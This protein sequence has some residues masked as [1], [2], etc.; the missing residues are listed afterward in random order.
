MPE[1]LF[2][3]LLLLSLI[4]VAALLFGRQYRALAKPVKI[5]S[6]THYVRTRRVLIIYIILFAIETVIAFQRHD[7]TWL[8]KLLVP[9]CFALGCGSF[10]FVFLQAR[11]KMRG[12]PGFAEK[13]PKRPAPVFLWQAIL[14]LLPVAVLALFGLFSLRQ[15]KLLAGQE[16]K[17]FGTVIAER[18]A[19]AIGTNVEQQLRDYREANFD[20]N[21][22]RTTDLGLSS[23]K[24]GVQSESN[25]W[26]RIKEWQQANP[27]INLPAMPVSDC[28]LDL[29]SESSSPQIY[30][31]APQP[32][33]WLQQLTPEQNQLWQAVKKAEFVSEDFSNMQSILEKFIAT[34]PPAGARA[35]AEYLL[36]LAE[37]HGMA[38]SEAVA[39]SARFSR[40]H[41]GDSDEPTDAGLPVGQLICYQTLRRLPDGAG[42]PAD[43][44]RFDTIAWM[45][46]Y[47]PS[48]FSPILIAETE[49]VERGTPLAQNAA[50]LKAWWESDERAR[51]V[52]R[53][54]RECYPVAAWT[55]G[56]FWVSSFGDRFLLALARHDGSVTEHSG[57]NSFTTNESSCFIL[58]LPQAVVN[59]A[60]GEV[61][62]NGDVSVP[63]YADVEVEIAGSKLQLYQGKFIQDTNTSALPLLG[64]AA[65][66][67]ADL[68]VGALATYPFHVRVLL[69]SPDIF[70]AR[71][72]QR[73]LL[74][75]AMI[76]LSTIAALIGL[77]AAYR[78]F[79]R[80]QQ[81]GELKSNFVSSVSHELRAP[82][83]SVRLMAENL[84]HG[85]VSEPQKQNEYFRFIVQECRRLSSLIENIL[86]FSRIEQGRKQYELEPTDP[87]AL[88]RQTVRLMEPCAADRQVQLESV[89]P[90]KT[91]SVELDGK[92]IQQALVNLIDNAIK[93]SPK[94]AAV[95]IGLECAADSL[96]LWVEDQGEGI[97]AGEHDKIF[98]R[99]YR[100]GSELRRET[101]GVGIGLSIVK[102]IVEAHGGKI[103]VR[104]EVGRGSRFTIELPVKH[105]LAPSL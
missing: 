35:N 77:I 63:T 9:G 32:P 94:G 11:R 89:F 87:V 29:K 50:T 78:A 4:L 44:V 62:L 88:A 36:L 2:I 71:Q 70:Y 86:D 104:S 17:E 27:E 7:Q 83:A 82:I 76:V 31:L 52:L 43:F 64:E 15:D 105:D 74:F 99:F 6:R 38:D 68:P 79:R 100:R 95:R 40:S 93:H 75:G 30:P 92:A 72:H 12:E 54:F 67:L 16:A 3:L 41:W 8:K 103:S 85:S 66:N 53:S 42:L 21:A 19:Q 5:D 60:V 101:Q 58:L 49:R 81:L 34:K 65:G 47:R 97:P 98:E 45:I 80:Q 69:A 48:I 56:L 91:V 14:I 46:Q 96:Q 59:K 37:T 10:F 1:K 55:N 33:E 22:N 23:W 73:T 13:N 84:E 28:W 24:G 20:L 61:V 25:A 39:Q 26:Q 90:D 57:T 102:H 18:L 51:D